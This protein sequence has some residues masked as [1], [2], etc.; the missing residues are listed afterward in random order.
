M[1]TA[2]ASPGKGPR[3]RKLPGLLKRDADYARQLLLAATMGGAGFHNLDEMAKGAFDAASAMRREQERRE[4]G[5]DQ[6][7]EFADQPE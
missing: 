3:K 4:K 6:P 5:A 2:V 7:P 1:K